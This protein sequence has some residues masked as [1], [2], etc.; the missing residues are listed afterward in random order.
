MSE[1]SLLQNL[2]SHLGVVSSSVRDACHVLEIRVAFDEQGRAEVK[3][4]NTLLSND[5]VARGKLC[6]EI[7]NA[8]SNDKLM[9]I[10]KIPQEKERIFLS[11][12]YSVRPLALSLVRVLI[13]AENSNR[14]SD[15][16]FLHNA[17]WLLVPVNT[18]DEGWHSADLRTLHSNQWTVEQV[19]QF[20][21]SKPVKYI[22]YHNAQ[23]IRCLDVDNN[24]FLYR[25][26]T[27]PPVARV[28]FS[29]VKKHR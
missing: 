15:R 17:R 25:K 18:K 2:C 28:K 20:M 14:E 23:V 5:Y 26:L 8:F 24:D 19:V 11:Y 1:K 10:Q 27:T 9:A 6:K 21:K 7:E 16:N 12:P 3:I 4:P 22:I 29:D 13:E